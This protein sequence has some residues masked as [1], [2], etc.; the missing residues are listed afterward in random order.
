M[1][2]Y[3]KEGSDNCKDIT[4][5]SSIRERL[6][7]PVHRSELAGRASGLTQ[8]QV[9]TSMSVGQTQILT[10]IIVSHSMSLRLPHPQNFSGPYDCETRA[11]H[12][13][14]SALVCCL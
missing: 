7:G 10:C 2:L 14:V 5:S 1:I 11:E 8:H 13:L 9:E 6:K 3:I 4:V 12:S